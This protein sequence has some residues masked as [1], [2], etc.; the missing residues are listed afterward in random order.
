MV[1]L[2]MLDNLILIFDIF[3]HS[4]INYARELPVNTAHLKLK[5]DN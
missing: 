5:S 2:Q 4:K 3:E 1:Y